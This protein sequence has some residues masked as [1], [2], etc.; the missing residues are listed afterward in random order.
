MTGTKW[1]ITRD[2]SSYT[3]LELDSLVYRKVTADYVTNNLCLN[4]LVLCVCLCTCVC[5]CVCVKRKI[6]TKKH[7]LPISWIYTFAMIQIAVQQ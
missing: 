6:T 3:K 1:K 4:E 2:K 5:M 7:H